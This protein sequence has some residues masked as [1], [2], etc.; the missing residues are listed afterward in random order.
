MF[1]QRRALF[2]GP[3][4]KGNLSSR[5]RNSSTSDIALSVSQPRYS[6]GLVASV[7]MVTSVV[8]LV[9]A[10]VAT[11]GTRPERAVVRRLATFSLFSGKL[12]F[13]P[14]ILTHV[15]SGYARP[16][17]SSLLHNFLERGH[18]FS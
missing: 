15:G 8:A 18:Y 12:H 7:A 10:V 9:V 4:P 11:V 6:P 2:G 1:G 5:F 14:S 13:P 17:A 16:T 3:P